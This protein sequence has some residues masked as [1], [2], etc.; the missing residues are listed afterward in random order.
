[1]RVQYKFYEKSQKFRQIYNIKY[2]IMRL[3]RLEI[4]E[5]E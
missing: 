5:T 3:I 1:M 2:D 4:C